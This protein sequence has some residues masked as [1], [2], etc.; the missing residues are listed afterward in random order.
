MLKSY[1]FPSVY[2]ATNRNLLTLQKIYWMVKINLDD[3]VTSS[4]PGTGRGIFST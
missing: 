4:V 1:N 2:E 3:T